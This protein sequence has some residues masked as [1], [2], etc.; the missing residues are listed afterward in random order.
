MNVSNVQT[1]NKEKEKGN[2]SIQI[3]SFPGIS[4]TADATAYDDN[5]DDISTD[6][7]KSHRLPS[8]SSCGYA[9]SCHGTPQ[10]LTSSYH[11]PNMDMNLY[12]NTEKNESENVIGNFLSESTS[13]NKMVDSL[14]LP[15][16]CECECEREYMKFFRNRWTNFNSEGKESDEKGEL[17]VGVESKCA[18]DLHL[19]KCDKVDRSSFNLNVCNRHLFKD[20]F[21]FNSSPIHQIENTNM[22]D[23]YSN[24]SEIDSN[25]KFLKDV[26]LFGSLKLIFQ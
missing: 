4:A 22:N 10:K 9:F 2:L 6:N 3:S 17:P 25:L 12:L 7:K 18:D 26:S 24:N 23:C 11:I 15:Q 14:C 20:N 5:D 16:N 13:K 1:M 19:L 8:S 21:N